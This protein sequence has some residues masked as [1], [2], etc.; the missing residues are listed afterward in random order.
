M[1][2]PVSHAR[3]SDLSPST[4]YQNF[5]EPELKSSMVLPISRYRRHFS[6]SQEQMVSLR[7]SLVFPV[8][9]GGVDRR[10]ILFREV[11]INLSIY[12]E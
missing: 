8:V 3:R 10:V 4:P 6:T 5:V 7:R 2:H 11:P 9:G 1:N 12:L